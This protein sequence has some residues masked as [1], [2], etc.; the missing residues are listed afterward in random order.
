MSTL[1][2]KVNKLRAQARAGLRAVQPEPVQLRL[3][4]RPTVARNVG[5]PDDQVAF[6]LEQSLRLKTDGGCWCLVT[7]ARSSPTGRHSQ[8]RCRC[9]CHVQAKA[10]A[11]AQGA[12]R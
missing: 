11:R 3:H 4:T 7:V 1:R 5:T 2:T 12:R 6:L 9:V 10:K 8:A